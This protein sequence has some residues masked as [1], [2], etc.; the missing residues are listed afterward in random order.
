MKL[1][2]EQAQK[3]I[4]H[5]TTINKGNPITCPIC[6][7]RNWKV[8][9]VVT[10]MREFQNGDLILGGDSAIMPFVSL[11]CDRCA[12]TLFINAISIGVVSPQVVPTKNEK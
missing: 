10:E 7:N 12:H 6:G 8:N 11:S 3:V 2:D 5:I 4:T 9:N 1:S